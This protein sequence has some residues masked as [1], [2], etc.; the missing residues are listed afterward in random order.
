MLRILILLA[1]LLGS[2]GA[3]A[4]S[5]PHPLQRA[6]EAA[7]DRWLRLR[8][9]L[10]SLRPTRL[11]LSQLRALQERR[12]PSSLQLL[13]VGCDFSD[14]L[15]VGRDRDDFPG[16]PAARRTAQL[17]PGTAIPVFAAHDSTYFDLQM[18]RVSDYFST[19]S[20]G[21]FSMSW[22]VHPVIV[23]LPR[24]MAY[25]GDPD[26][27]DVRVVGMAREVIDAIDD[28]VDFSLYDT[29]VLIHAGAG[30]ETDILG[31]S[32]EQIFSNYLDQRD[33]ASAAEAGILP[34]PELV[35]AETAVE[36][37][38]ILPESESQDPVGSVGGF[39]DVRGVYCFEFGLRLGML[40]LAD[41]TPSSFPDSQGIG[42]FGLMGYGLFTGLGIVPAA[43]CAM[44][45][46]RR[47]RR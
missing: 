47:D 44:T 45:R 40:S 37:V 11:K 46:G 27:S 34:A 35:T 15:M 4:A 3:G 20:F 13:V 38:L 14:S 16:W 5:A 22:D 33:F 17:I 8:P 39:F 26:S 23:N 9:R 6:D 31:D 36:H 19:V 41:F 7:V 2:S 1:L 18:R 25:Y 12:A 32:R 43:P 10:E 28:D 42:N 29:V 24:P 30:K 21:Q